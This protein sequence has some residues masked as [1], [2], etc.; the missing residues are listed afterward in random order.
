MKKV[1]FDISYRPQ[2]ESGECKVVTRND[3]PARII[4]WDCKGN[5]PII[6]LFEDEPGEEFSTYYTNDGK[7]IDAEDSDLFVLLPDTALNEQYE[8]GYHQGLADAREKLPH[9]K[10]AASSMP[11]DG[12]NFSTNTLFWRGYQVP[13][14][15]LERAL[16]KDPPSDKP[17]S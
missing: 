15:D 13:L 7:S 6:A 3:R 10:P 1:P 8:R 11:I 9:W 17:S 14:A 12:I 2:I 4:C 5:I 16:P